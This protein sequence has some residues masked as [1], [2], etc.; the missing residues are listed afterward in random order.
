MKV[1]FVV[2][3]IMLASAYSGYALVREGRA[4][5]APED[6]AQPVVEQAVTQ[7]AVEVGNKICPV[8][9]ENIEAMGEGFKYEY[10][11]KIYNFCCSM[12]LKDFLKD[13]EKYSKIAE[14]SAA[15]QAQGSAAG[16]GESPEHH[17]DD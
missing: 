16:E 13:P 7:P 17:H 2:L 11:G 12:C 8:S 6:I 14:K 5:P 9:G 15:A 10:N 4:Q 3:S 1:K